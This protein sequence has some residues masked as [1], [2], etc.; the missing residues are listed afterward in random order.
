MDLP[1]VVFVDWCSS[2]C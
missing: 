1:A 2:S